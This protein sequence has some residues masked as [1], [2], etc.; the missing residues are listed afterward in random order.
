MAHLESIIIPAH[1]TIWN[2]YNKRELRI[3]FAL[4][5]KGR[6]RKPDSLFLLLVLVDILTLMFI[7]NAESIFRFI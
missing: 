4:P 3:E 5:E 6:T 7:K 1:H 2:G